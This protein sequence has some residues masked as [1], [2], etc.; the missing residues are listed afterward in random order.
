MRGVNDLRTTHPALAAQWHPTK[1]GG[2]VPEEF[3]AG[4][5]RKVWWLCDKGHEWQASISSRSRGIGCPVCAG[6]LVVAGE[7]DLSSFYPQIAAEWDA[8]KNGRLTP[9]MLTPYSNRRVWWRCGLGHEYIAA[10]A[11]RTMHGS[12]C[13]YCAGFKALAGFNDLATLDPD[14]AAQWHTEL[15]EKLTPEM[16][17]LGSRKKV[18]WQCSQGHVWAAVIHSRTGPNHCG[19]PVCAGKVSAKRIKRYAAITLD[20]ADVK[21]NAAVFAKF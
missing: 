21:R 17:T 12:G 5:H 7:N 18:W 13:P 14:V 2:L 19:C 3:V 15:N 11:A 6:K 20:A 10:V 8:E 16:V 1:N 9:Q 4:T